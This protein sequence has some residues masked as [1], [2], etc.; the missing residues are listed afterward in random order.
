M[1][2]PI[3]LFLLHKTV[4]FKD[5]CIACTKGDFFSQL[6]NRI[7]LG[8]RH[9]ARS[10]TVKVSVAEWKCGSDSL[11]LL[12]YSTS[13][14]VFLHCICCFDAISLNWSWEGG[15]EQDPN[16]AEAHRLGASH[17]GTET[18][19]ASPPAMSAS[20]PST[21]G[22]LEVNIAAPHSITWDESRPG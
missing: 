18:S 4:F 12:P 16:L 9:S 11:L 6:S 13:V 14:F 20:C 22:W 17:P 15:S 21:E 8:I 19:S 2:L 5:L 7:D 10:Q 3:N 1:I